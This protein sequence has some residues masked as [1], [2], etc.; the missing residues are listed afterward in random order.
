MLMVTGLAL[1]SAAAQVGAR[2]REEHPTCIRRLRACGITRISR[3]VKKFLLHGPVI[4]R[5]HST[6]CVECSRA[7]RVSMVDLNVEDYVVCDL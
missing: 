2:E 1:G 4:Y 5:L 6:V 7:L 3:G